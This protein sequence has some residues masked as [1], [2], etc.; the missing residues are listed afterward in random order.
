MSKGR[1]GAEHAPL[2]AYARRHTVVT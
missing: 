2:G 1:P